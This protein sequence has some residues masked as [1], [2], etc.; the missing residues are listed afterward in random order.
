MVAALLKFLHPTSVSTDMSDQSLF[1]QS[2]IVN[3]V[4]NL[5]YLVVEGL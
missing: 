2:Q 1:M 3:E 4:H 5:L